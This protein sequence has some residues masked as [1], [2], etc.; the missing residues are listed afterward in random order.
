MSV[1][2]IIPD[3]GA[4]D[5]RMT[6]VQWLVEEGAEVS[7]GDKLAAIETDKAVVELESVASGILLKKC[8]AEG[9]DA[10]AGDVIA[11]VGKLGD[12]VPE[13]PDRD[14]KVVAPQTEVASPPLTTS[15][16]ATIPNSTNTP[17][18]GG[19]PRMSPMLRNLARHKGVNLDDV[20][21]TGA[22]GAIT[23]QDILAAAKGKG[24]NG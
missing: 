9:E 5:D 15:T 17:S 8:A 2:I 3:F 21:G 11:Y 10:V 16:T 20:V 1:P 7:R 12:V 6:I 18:T 14:H 22:G 4:A 13:A 23:R 24:S 19:E